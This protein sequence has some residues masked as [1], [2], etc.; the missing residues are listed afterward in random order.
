MSGGVAGLL[1]CNKYKVTV[2]LYLKNKLSSGISLTA[3]NGSPHWKNHLTTLYDS[4]GSH[5]RSKRKKA[6]TF[7]CP[8]KGETQPFRVIP[9]GDTPKVESTWVISHLHLPQLP[10][11]SLCEGGITRDCFIFLPLN[12][13]A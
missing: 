12:T 5:R 4:N 2:G 13:L 8:E 3:M 11:R 7:A 9:E 1:R 6:V 10:A